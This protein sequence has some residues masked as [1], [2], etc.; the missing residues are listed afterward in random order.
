VDKY[1]HL[2]VKGTHKF[3]EF[4]LTYLNKEQW[5]SFFINWVEAIGAEYLD[6]FILLEF[7]VQNG[8]NFLLL[9]PHEVVFEKWQGL[10]NIEI[11]SFQKP[12]VEMLIEQKFLDFIDHLPWD[13]SLDKCLQLL[14]FLFTQLRQ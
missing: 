10:F 2:V 11:I 14:L 7:I 12:G 13:D 1:I 9:S 6:L 8:V 4:D 3:E 5:P